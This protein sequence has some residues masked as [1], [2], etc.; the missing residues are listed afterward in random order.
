LLWDAKSGSVIGHRSESNKFSENSSTLT[1][2]VLPAAL[3]TTAF[4]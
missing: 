3:T 4:W 2:L 1:A